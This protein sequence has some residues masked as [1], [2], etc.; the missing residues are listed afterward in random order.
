LSARKIEG[1]HFGLGS[2]LA[3]TRNSLKAIGGFEP[4]LDYLADD[5]ELGKRISA[6]GFELELSNLV[7]DTFL[8]AY[9]CGSF[10]QHQ[11]RWSRTVRDAR[12]P[13]YIGVVLAFGLPWAVLAFLLSGG[14]AWASVLLVVAAAMRL[15]VALLVSGQV[16][17]DRRVLRHLYL[18]PLRDFLGLVIWIASFAGNSVCWRG[19]E[20]ILDNGKLRRVP[21]KS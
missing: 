15:A 13:A 12:R 20:F 1:V 2:T 7:V 3:F 17:R 18:L 10:W 8:P 19:T 16:L 4:I 9:S 11:L 5:Y 21:I 14:A 6:A